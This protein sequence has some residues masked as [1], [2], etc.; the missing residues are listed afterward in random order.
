MIG[1]E[2]NDAVA[3]NESPASSAVEGK[4]EMN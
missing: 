2:I 1:N 3:M 4:V